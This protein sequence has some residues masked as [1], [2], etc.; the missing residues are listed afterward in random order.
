MYATPRKCPECGVAAD[1]PHV[2]PCSFHERYEAAK[3][4]PLIDWLASLPA[5]YE[6]LKARVVAN[7][8][9]DQAA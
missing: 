7:E 1:E 5:H 4:G 8:P 9:F 6:R 3:R 2:H